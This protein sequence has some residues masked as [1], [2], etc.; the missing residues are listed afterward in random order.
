MHGGGSGCY[1]PY[2]QLWQRRA[3]HLSPASIGLL[4]AVT[5][6]VN[7]IGVPLL[8]SLFD[9]FARP[10][11][12]F[13]F[14]LVLNALLHIGYVGLPL[15]MADATWAQPPPW[16]VVALPALAVG[17]TVHGSTYSLVDTVTLL[18]LPDKL[19]YGRVRLWAGVA[20]ALSSLAVG[21]AV[22]DA[23]NN[24]TVVGSS[25]PRA[26][27]RQPHLFLPRRLT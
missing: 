8:C 11:R 7:T 2:L 16:L 27:R 15:L 5:C 18:R 17:E 4:S 1:S 14:M 10:T 12:C 9:R 22:L 6:A 21:T 23:E 20:W 25:P 13:V 26:M 24:S 3:L 19:M